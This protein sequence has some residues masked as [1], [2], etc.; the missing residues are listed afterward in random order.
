MEKNFTLVKLFLLLFVIGITS[1]TKAQPFVHPGLP[2]NKEDLALLKE[3]IQKEPWLSA[4]NRFKSDYRSLLT[5][6]MRGPFVEVGRSP[7]INRNAWQIDMMAIHHLALMWIF[8]GDTAYAR[9]ATDM[10]DAW[11]V[12]NTIWGG[13]ENMLDMGDYAPYY[14]TGA[15]I[16]RGTYPGWTAENTAHVK[17]YF[18]N[19]Y[20]PAS[21]VP[22]PL[23]DHNKGALQLAVALGVAAFCD[24][25]L[26]WNQALDVYRM[27]GGGGL[28]NSLA[29]GEVADAG[30][31]DHWYV[32]A[33]ALMW[34][35]EIAWK[36]GVDLFAEMD[37]RLLAV[38]ELYNHYAINNTGL[39]Y[40]PLGGYS[41]YYTNWGIPT[42]ARHQDAFNNII[43]AAYSLRK[44]IP[45]PYT[46]SMRTLVGE[47][48]TSFLYLKSED[49]STAT[50]LPPVPYAVTE[51]ATSLTNI[52]IG[53]TGISGNAVYKDGVWTITAAGAGGAA[54]YTFKP[55]KGN[56]TMI[57][58]LDSNS[59]KTA[60][61]GIMM[62]EQLTP[63]GNYVAV[64]LNGT[65]TVTA[66]GSGY[67]A[68]RISTHD[69]S[70]VNKTGSWWLKLER[71]GQ[72]VFTWHSHDGINWSNNG[73]YI[74][75][76]GEDTYMGF[77]CSSGSSSEKNIAVC[78]NVRI[79]NGIPAGAPIINSPLNV[80]GLADTTFS[81]TITASNSPV[82]FQ[83]SGLPAG[84]K[85]DSL[86]G[87]ISGTATAVG[88]SIVTL[89][90]TNAKGSGTAV[91]VIKMFSKVPPGVP[92]RLGAKVTSGVNITIS[93]RGAANATSYKVYRSR[94]Y[95]GP[96]IA[97]DSGLTN[98]SYTDNDPY[99]GVNSYYV[100]TA[101]SGPLESARSNVAWISV[102]PDVPAQP[103]VTNKNAQLILNWQPAVGAIKY[104][105]KRAATTGGPYVTIDTV[106]AVAY[107]DN[108]VVNG[109]AYYYVIA[110]MNET[111]ESANSA[112]VFGMPGGSGATWSGA[113][114]ADNWSNAGD[115]V[116]N[117]VPGSPAILTFKASSKSTINNDITG[118]KVARILFDADASQYTIGGN[119][120][121]WKK[122]LVNNS[123]W[124]QTLNIPMVLD[125]QLN[126]ITNTQP[127]TITGAI[128]GSQG[129][130][131]AGWSVLYLNGDN[132]YAGNTTIS[133]WG[134]NWPPVNGIGIQGI[135]TGTPGKPTSGPLGT[136]KIIMDGGSLF[137]TADAT[138]WN[139]IVVTEGK[140]SD[141]FQ[142]GG[143]LNLMGNIT[144][145]G[146][147]EEDGNNYGGLNLWGDNSNF[148]GS[149]IC[150]NRSGYTRFQFWVPESG[151]PKAHFTLLNT[152]VDAA[153]IRFSSGTLHFGALWGPGSFKNRAGGA[154]IV[155]IGALNVNSVYD[156]SMQNTLC[157]E[158][159]GT[160]ILVFRGSSTYTGTTTV[161]SGT[162]LL[163]NNPVTG[164]FY[165][166]IT[167]VGGVFGGTGKS[168][169]NV[170]IGT[171]SGTGASLEPG[172]QGIGT[173]IADSLKINADGTYKV[174]LSAVDK[175]ADKIVVT[176]VTLNNAS[177]ALTNL[178][179]D[180]MSIGNT[181]TIVDN[182]GTAA[183]KGTFKG[184][185]EGAQLTAGKD[186][187]N[188]TYKGGTGNDIVLTVTKPV[189]VVDTTVVDTT[190]T[191]TVIVARKDQYV[192][193]AHIGDRIV[194]Q[195]DLLLD[196]VASSGLP[197]AFSSSD[198]N[199]VIVVNDSLRT[200][201]AGMVTI[202][203]IQAGNAD[204][205]PAMAQQSFSVTVKKDSAAILASI[206][207]Y[208]NPADDHFII[209]LSSVLPGALLLIHNNR[210]ELIHTQRLTDTNTSV[211]IKSWAAGMY[212]I[213][214]KNGY[215]FDDKLIK[216]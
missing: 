191:D 116:E 150:R 196:A 192:T 195:E 61:T 55:V 53:S 52:D 99:P 73:L 142:T 180:S 177:L 40:I 209:H 27:D 106:T 215:L 117:G 59:I 127:I 1:A 72:R 5:Y 164:S 162:F 20:W 186:N 2:F 67:T 144:G 206:R 112:A 153:S 68:S 166:D 167:A 132:T 178:N 37:N 213:R 100:V 7:D 80:D 141:F 103:V 118:L 9:K 32:Q 151:S 193:F 24:D 155:S 101:T 111:Q 189:E 160:G 86:T 57:V 6:G 168:T 17:K 115:W 123:A 77:F 207:I 175:T 97:L 90:A 124:L 165:S 47:G 30:R 46:D 119:S 128:S 82:M 12:T 110:A 113:P 190:V 74:T 158:K 145:N 143:A 23:R 135:G 134:S 198:N 42:G 81:Y 139:D 15:D 156:G 89:K 204:Y 208:P 98:L 70:S 84:L 56:A 29:N 214:I 64:N 34:G 38:G 19:V 114:V 183:V 78:S 91:L 179:A 60:V 71:V 176:A 138:L 121:A 51:P 93:W 146:T 14:I 102:P 26:K 185:Q 79:S 154:P 83:A 11:A 41:T 210:G 36:Q 137:S 136:G 152:S 95:D 10:L 49:H 75:N 161:R 157:V 76:M 28:R 149:F 171:G 65:N 184:L 129:L 88:T 211:N 33:G 94:S 96:F 122:E 85:I 35:A 130:V 8:T 22:G 107:T 212:Y 39:E 172:D 202:T 43:Q 133:G 159:V 147:L 200:L 170:T 108:N 87:I 216:R 3:N 148:T 182:T 69:I 169:G 31:D 203:A 174:E 48:I 126:I 105:V 21:W 194:G 205:K 25:T 109:I 63:G 140:T 120:I 13:S 45:T 4:Y 181:F 187:F 16:L 104:T 62:R 199:V 92:T 163:N 54:N 201:R 197:L 188:I 44:G 131:K 66:G 173:F 125:S 58:K 50:P 18:A